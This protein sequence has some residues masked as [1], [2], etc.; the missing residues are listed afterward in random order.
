MEFY[1]TLLI[2]IEW[3]EYNATYNTNF[4]FI[5]GGYRYGCVSLN[6]LRKKAKVERV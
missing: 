4:N 5:R 1:K 6:D 3:R 2:K